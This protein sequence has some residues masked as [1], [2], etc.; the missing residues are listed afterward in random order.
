MLTVG[1]LIELLSELP[2]GAVIIID[3]ETVS[4]VTLVGGRLKEGYL[5]KN[6]SVI[7][8]PLKCKQTAIKFTKWEELSDGSV[9]EMSI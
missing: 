3:D 7:N 9:V 2:S 1:S 8:D 4:G 6:F 5:N